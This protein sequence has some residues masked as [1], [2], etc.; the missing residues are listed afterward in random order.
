MKMV[1]SEFSQITMKTC[2]KLTKGAAFRELL[3]QI[4]SLTYLVSDEEPLENPHKQ[5]NI[6][7][8][9]LNR[10]TTMD[11][12]LLINKPEKNENKRSLHSYEKLPVRNRKKPSLIGRVGA[13]N[14][15]QKRAQVINVKS[16]TLK[17]TG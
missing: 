10:S 15:A 3:Q 14:E 4:K 17:K 12:G 13:E 11:F 7:L 1:I 9:E 16:E 5:L 2:P 8:D 6:I